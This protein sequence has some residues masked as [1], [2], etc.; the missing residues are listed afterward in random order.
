MSDDQAPVLLR[1]LDG[2]GAGVRTTSFGSVGTIL[3]REST[4]VVWVSKEGEAIDPD[5]F[6]QPCTDVLCVLRGQLRVEF[7]REAEPDVTLSP[8]DVLVLPPDTACRAYSWPRDGTQ[9]T[10][11]L[12]VSARQSPRGPG[13][14]TDAGR[15]AVRTHGSH[16]RS[17]SARGVAGV[18]R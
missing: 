17:S 16:G 15:A 8:G 12:A 3:D 6:S 10:V 14:A 2:E 13:P 7:A 4:E 11:F 1:V 5:W 18:A 9:R